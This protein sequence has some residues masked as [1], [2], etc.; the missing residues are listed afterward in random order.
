M[1]WCQR[2]VDV[3]LLIVSIVGRRVWEPKWRWWQGLQRKKIMTL[4]NYFFSFSFSLRV[5]DF[6]FYYFFLNF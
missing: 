2:L 1:V 6:Y 4:Y 3:G 5:I